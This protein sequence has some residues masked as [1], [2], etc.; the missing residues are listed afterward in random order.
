MIPSNVYCIS[1]VG[2]LFPGCVY[3]MHMYSVDR[4]VVAVWVSNN[5]LA[6]LNP[7]LSLSLSLSTLSLCCTLQLSNE[8]EEVGKPAARGVLVNGEPASPAGSNGARKKGKL[9][10]L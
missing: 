6:M 9:T 1:I 5:Q 2:I 8:D 4:V 10:Y 3:S 7:S